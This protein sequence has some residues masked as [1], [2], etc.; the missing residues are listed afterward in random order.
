[1]E[2]NKVQGFNPSRRTSKNLWPPLRENLATWIG[3][4]V[5]SKT[6]IWRRGFFVAQ[7][8]QAYCVIDYASGQDNFNFNNTILYVTGN[9]FADTI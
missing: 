3:E 8:V 1:M 5:S 2:Y 7:G 6:V 4:D 9:E